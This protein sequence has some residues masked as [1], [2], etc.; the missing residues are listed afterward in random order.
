[1]ASTDAMEPMDAPVHQVCPVF[2]VNAVYRDRSEITVLL[3]NPATAASIPSALKAFAEIRAL[4]GLRAIQERMESTAKWAPQEKPAT[5]VTR[6]APDY[7]VFRVIE[8]TRFM[9]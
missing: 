2:T 4:T 8:V 7:R 6:A 5:R 1:M 3:E 9:E